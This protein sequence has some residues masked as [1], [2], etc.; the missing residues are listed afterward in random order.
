MTTAHS[1]SPNLTPESEFVIRPWEHDAEYEVITDV[2]NR[3]LTS[4][5]LDNV[6]DVGDVR[7]FLE[8][9]PHIDRTQDA[10]L[11]EV[12]GQVVAYGDAT[13]SDE[14]EGS[15]VYRADMYVLPENRASGLPEALFR[16]LIERLTVLASGHRGVEPKILH[17]GA[18]DSERELI[19][20]LKAEGFQPARHFFRMVRPTLES[21]PDLPLPPGLE[22]RPVQAEHLRAIFDAKD[23]AFRDHW[24]HRPGNEEDYQHWLH[25]TEFQPDLWKVAW[26]GDQVAGMVL[27]FVDAPGNQRYHRARGY[28][29]DISVRRPWR[30]RGLA[31]ALIALSLK[32]LAEAGM[33]EA[34]LNVDSENLSGALGLYESLGYQTSWTSTAYRKSFQA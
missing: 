12:D 14:S 26:A 6:R 20:L 27:N 10:L 5:G 31:R 11:G 23:E 32:A 34:A 18:G 17:A 3:S 25:S 16:A 21:I 28:T 33:T 24:G 13:W 9:W 19:A 22:V 2:I 8:H 4:D 15:R 7:N 1:L 29:E 30:R